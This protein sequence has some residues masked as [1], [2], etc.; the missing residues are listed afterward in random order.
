MLPAKLASVI[1]QVYRAVWVHQWCRVPVAV[2]SVVPR[3][4][5]AMRRPVQD[6]SRVLL[7]LTV[8][9]LA[10]EDSKVRRLGHAEAPVKHRLAGTRIP[11]LTVAEEDPFPADLLVPGQEQPLLLED[12]HLQNQIPETCLCR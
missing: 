9:G 4:A 1:E 6:L 11:E 2:R 12:N 5:T 3:A 8:G 7:V 10:P